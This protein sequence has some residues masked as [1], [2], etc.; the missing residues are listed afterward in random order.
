MNRL[1]HGF[2]FMFLFNVIF[3]VDPLAQVN[4]KRD[5]IE[6]QLATLRDFRVQLEGVSVGLFDAMKQLKDQKKMVDDYG[7][8]LDQLY[9]GFVTPY[10]ALKKNVDPTLYPLLNSLSAA[11]RN[12]LKM[13][14]AAAHLGVV[15]D[16]L[17]RF[18][19]I[20]GLVDQTLSA[21]MK[22]FQPHLGVFD[23]TKDEKGIYQG[24]AKTETA[25]VAVVKNIDDLVQV[26]QPLLSLL[27]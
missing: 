24:I 8:I 20:L 2:F 26:L 25:L 14:L 19:Q 10:E 12:V 17:I 27:K 13:L 7:G 15:S 5:E 22:G 9:Q 18:K 4:E 16:L 1:I 3:A 23:K 21:V 6:K 11:H